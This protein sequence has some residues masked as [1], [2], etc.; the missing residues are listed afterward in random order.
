VTPVAAHEAPSDGR[1]VIREEHQAGMLR[2]GHVREKVEPGVVVDEAVP[3]VALLRTDVVWT[4]EW[5]AH[6][7]YGP[8][9]ADEVVVAWMYVSNTYAREKVI[10]LT[11]LGIELGCES[12]RITCAIGK[13][14]LRIPVSAGSHMRTQSTYPICYSRETSVSRC[15]LA[16]LEHGGL[17]QVRDIIGHLKIP[18]AKAVRRVRHGNGTI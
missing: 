9:E 6:E 3:G 10:V 1:S 16:R 11:F 8:V 13:L 2:L 17:G 15:L 14:S 7:K 18:K 5:V 4:H 12:A